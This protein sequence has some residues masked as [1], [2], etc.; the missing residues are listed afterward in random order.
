MKW[1]TY[2]VFVSS[3]FA[4]MQAERDYLQ[5]HVFPLI[6]SELRRDCISLRIIDLRFGIN[7][8][9]T[10]EESVEEKV[11]R[12]C[13][14]EINR[15]RP[16]FLGLL[17]NRYG[18][19]P[20]E[21][22]LPRLAKQYKGQSITAI[23]IMHGFLQRDDIRGCLFMERDSACYEHIP[24]K[25]RSEEYDDSC[26]SEKQQDWEK[27]QSLKQSIKDRLTEKQRSEC[28]HEYPAR[29][30]GH[31]MTDLEDFGNTVKEAILNEI[32][33]H[34]T[35]EHND[36]PFVDEQRAQEEFLH[37]HRE[38]RYLRNNLFESV[39]RMIAAGGSM[40]V[41]TGPEGSGK[42]SLYTALVDSFCQR[43]NVITLFHATDTGEE[44]R[45]TDHMLARWIYQLEYRLGVSHQ[46]PID[47]ETRI[48]YFRSL[49]RKVP[50]GLTLVL[51]IDGVEGFHQT[52]VG[53]YLTFY[54]KSIIANCCLCCTCIPGVADEL[55]TYH[56]SLRRYDMPALTRDEAEG[57]IHTYAAY[58]DKELYPQNVNMLLSKGSET[59]TN[60]ESPLWLVI[61]LQ[62]VTR[63]NQR[64]F[65]EVADLAEQYEK[66]FDKGLIASIDE[67]I[68]SF[69]YREEKLFAAYLN[70]IGEAYGALPTKVFQYLSASYNGLDECVLAELLGKVWDLRTFAIVRSFLRGFITEQSQMKTWQLVHRKVRIPLTAAEKA[71]LCGDI[72]TIYLHKLDTNQL[73]TDNLFYYLFHNNDTLN[74]FHY[75]F[76]SRWYASRVKEELIG[77][78]EVIGAEELLTFLFATFDQRHKGIR[79]LMPAWVA[80][81]RIKDCIMDIAHAACK[82]G[83][84]Q[85]AVLL[86]DKFHAF[87]FDVHIP[88]DIKLLNYMLTVEIKMDATERIYS[89]SQQI[90]EYCRAIDRMKI[91]GPISLLFAP[92][93]KWYYN[94]K[95]T[96]LK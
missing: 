11:L 45:S 92:V 19:T 12:V 77:V 42:S 28:Y 96:K 31:G 64:D 51:F 34:Y 54:P 95:I 58:E 14:D 17:G 71:A 81:I 36:E 73:V 24:L 56:H 38:R 76:S 61:A 94:W 78:S 44:N 4:D 52:P 13:M 9:E 63:L 69:P 67:K 35:A 74:A 57:I 75:I 93:A 89:D 43:D 33:A 21:S 53:K 72:A 84:Y 79:K 65:K 87:L 30:D 29:W 22:Q 62:Y 32:H 37:L 49:L 3:T 47:A 26:N 55:L 60:F 80:M 5:T 66:S 70:R 88:Y 27:L 6:N 91:R 41:I 46:D 59:Q 48:T 90:R 1:R 7:T 85:M 16:F 10:S 15:S 83:D 20:K 82:R 68:K 86:I 40:L 2:S 50:E 18:T 8:L 25:L 39:S 23:E